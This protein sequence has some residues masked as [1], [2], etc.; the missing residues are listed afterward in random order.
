MHE[1]IPFPAFFL[2][3]IPNVLDI[4]Q[5]QLMS[6]RLGDNFEQQEGLLTQNRPHDVFNRVFIEKLSVN[7]LAICRLPDI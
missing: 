3:H 1:Q 2:Q 6:F 4:P 5:I 7:N